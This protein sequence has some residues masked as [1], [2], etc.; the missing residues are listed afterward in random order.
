MP[1][2]NLNRGLGPEQGS[3]W[4]LPVLHMFIKDHAIA[5]RLQFN[6]LVCLLEKSV[7]CHFEHWLNNVNK[8]EREDVSPGLGQEQDKLLLED[9]LGGTGHM[10]T[11]DTMQV[12]G[13]CSSLPV[14]LVPWRPNSSLLSSTFWP[15]GAGHGAQ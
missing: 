12:S 14:V 8:E 1:C 13:D 4:H 2:A 15:N 6:R 5:S 10:H 3:Y 9:L 11:S 7:L